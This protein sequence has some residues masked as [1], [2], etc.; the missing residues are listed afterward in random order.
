MENDFGLVQRA[1]QYNTTPCPLLSANIWEL[2]SGL[3]YNI[4]I[5]SVKKTFARGLCNNNT[6]DKT[7]RVSLIH[8]NIASENMT[9]FI[10]VYFQKLLAYHA[11]DWNSSRSG[12]LL[13]KYSCHSPPV[14]LCKN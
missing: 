10:T 12:L 1:N 3:W 8:L 14:I 13:V 9:K 7:C 5:G 4:K 11:L 2:H 6:I